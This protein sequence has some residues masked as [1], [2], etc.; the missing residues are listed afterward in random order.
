MLRS[1]LPAPKTLLGCIPLEPGVTAVA[2]LLLAWNLLNTV[3]GLKSPWVLYNVWMVVSSCAL[4]Y[5]KYKRD[6]SHAR[7]FA[8]ALFIDIMVYA[9]SIPYDKEFTMSDAEQCTI[10]MSTNR[11]MTM[12][13]C[14]AHVHEI[15]NIAYMIRVASLLVKTYLAGLA[16]SYELTFTQS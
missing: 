12:E 1:L 14:L 16:R 3:T 2:T 6:L 11:D 4:F 15:R 5:A 8:M 10:A 13:H 7:W 9:V